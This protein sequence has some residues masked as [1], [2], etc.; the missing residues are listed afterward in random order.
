MGNA[1]NNYN[2]SGFDADGVLKYESVATLSSAFS[3]GGNS[4]PITMNGSRVNTA[5][6]FAG[7]KMFVRDG[8][9][10]I[11]VGTI[12]G[13]SLPLT[14]QGN[15]VYNADI[16]SGADIYIEPFKEPKYV[17]NMHHL[18]VSY[19]EFDNVINIF[20]NRSLVLSAKHN[21]AGTF[22]FDRSDCLIGR[23]TTDGT[24]TARNASQYMGEFHEMSLERGTK[25]KIS[26]SNSLFPFFDDTL[27]YLRFEEVD[28]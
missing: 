19:N 5:T 23:T 3:A 1:D 16:D 12:A 15:Q 10:F 2:Y 7:Q 20:Y 25:K 13:A 8:F 17:K 26:Y 22:E 18:A 27:L 21:T 28:E 24:I 11:E 6:F 4:F 9:D 14:L